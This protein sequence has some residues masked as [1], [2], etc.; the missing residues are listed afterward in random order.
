MEAILKFNLPEERQDFMLAAKAMSFW[1]VLWEL[2]QHLRGKTK[3]ASDDM[4]EGEYNAYMAIRET[5][6]ELMLDENISL[7]MVK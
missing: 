4:S 5:L 2:D 3:Y 6:R 7:D 1:S